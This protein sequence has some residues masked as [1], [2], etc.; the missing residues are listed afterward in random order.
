MT[1]EFVIPVPGVPSVPVA[2]TDARFPVHR[3]YCVGRNYAE[4]AKEMGSVVDREVPTFFMKP[5]D[6]AW[7]HADAPYPPATTN[8]HHE[9]ELVIALAS[10]GTDIDPARALDHVFGYAVG[11]DLTRRD[12]Q[13]AAK[14]KGNPWDTAKG[15]DASAPIAPIAP[16]AAIGHPA[17]GE[18]ALSINGVERQRADIATMIFK[19]PEILA[20]LSR[21]YTLAPGDLV[22]TGTPAGVGP[23]RPGDAFEATFPGL[24]ALRG[25]MR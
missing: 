8:L 11:L 23:L 4:H 9:V 15:F 14:A 7:P 19:V 20:A 12:L 16:A 25:T 6:A 10:G 18:L 22:F 1:A 13:A 3:I 24:P 17:A 21:L 5:A 2:G